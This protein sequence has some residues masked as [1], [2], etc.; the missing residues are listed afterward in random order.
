M[1]ELLGAFIAGIV[2]GVVGEK[3]RKRKADA[4]AVTPAPGGSRFRRP[5]Q[6]PRGSSS[7][8]DRIEGGP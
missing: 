6:P 2:L 1:I 5:L 8:D 4:R 7:D 3:A